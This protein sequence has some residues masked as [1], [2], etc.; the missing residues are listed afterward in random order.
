MYI[1]IYIYIYIYMYMYIYIYIYIYIY[2]CVYIYIYIYIIFICIQ[3]LLQYPKINGT[4]TNMYCQ[5]QLIKYFE[6]YIQ[7]M[8]LLTNITNNMF[9]NFKGDQYWDR[10]SICEILID[11]NFIYAII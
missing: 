4:L 9:F 7:M 5:H 1:Y 3:H 11:V 6:D 2:M 8:K 10:S